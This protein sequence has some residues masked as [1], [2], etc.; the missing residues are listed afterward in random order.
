MTMGSYD[1]AETCELL[2]IYMLSLITPKFKA[3]LV[4]TVTMVWRYVMQQL[5]KLKKTKQE[6]CEIFK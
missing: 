5:R 2:G 3:K 6:V 4:S 1:R